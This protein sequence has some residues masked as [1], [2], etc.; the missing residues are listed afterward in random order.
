MSMQ[1]ELVCLIISFGAVVYTKNC[2]LGLSEVCCQ[3]QVFLLS[4]LQIKYLLYGKKKKKMYSYSRTELLC[5]F[6][7]NCN[8]LDFSSCQCFPSLELEL[9]IFLSFSRNGSSSYQGECYKQ[10]GVF[11]TLYLRD[12]IYYS[13]VG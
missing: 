12:D 9:I 5:P 7:T 13:F 10:I 6:F 2:D 8:K 3:D 4:E 1:L 11:C